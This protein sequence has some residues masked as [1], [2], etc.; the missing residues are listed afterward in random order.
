MHL[1][2]IQAVSGGRASVVVTACAADSL[3]IT[4]VTV[5]FIA[6]PVWQVMV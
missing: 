3:R 5:F 2:P 6:N 1:A 4:A